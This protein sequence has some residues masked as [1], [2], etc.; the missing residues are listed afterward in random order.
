M[1]CRTDGRCHV[2][3]TAYVMLDLRSMSCWIDLLC[4]V[5]LKVYVMLD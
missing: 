3:M 1:S 5:G 2:G 4:H